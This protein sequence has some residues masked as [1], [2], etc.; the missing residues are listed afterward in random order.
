ME[1]D[2]E[3]QDNGDRVFELEEAS[4]TVDEMQTPVAPANTDEV[5]CNKL[6]NLP[7][8]KVALSRTDIKPT[9]MEQMLL[10]V[11]MDPRRLKENPEN[12]NYCCTHECERCEMFMKFQCKLKRTYKNNPGGLGGSYHA[13]HTARHSENN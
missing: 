1:V 10:L 13:V 6:L 11:K 4:L 2:N 5:L 9:H 8:S 12:K 7:Y 3:E